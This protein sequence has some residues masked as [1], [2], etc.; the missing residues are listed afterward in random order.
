MSDEK[1]KIGIDGYF[2]FKK[3]FASIKPA[4]ISPITAVKLYSNILGV[5]EIV[6][7]SYISTSHSKYLPFPITEIIIPDLG[8]YLTEN[9]SDVP[10]ILQ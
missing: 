6:G 8:K 2:L 7:F 10:Y 9:V 1:G 3:Y 4:S 5:G